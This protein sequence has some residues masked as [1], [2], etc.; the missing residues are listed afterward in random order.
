MIKREIKGVVVEMY[1]S[2]DELP[3][4]RFHKYNKF[5][6]IDSGVGSDINDLSAKIDTI[7]HYVKKENKLAITELENMRQSLYLISSELSPKHLAFAVLVHSINGEIQRDY[8]DDGLSK[9]VERLGKGKKSFI[10]GLI[11]SI[12]KKINQELELYFPGR[13]NDVH[14]KEYYDKL[15]ERTLLMLD[16]LINE[17]SNKFKIERIDD[18]LLELSKPQLFSGKESA[19]IKYDKQFNEMCIF[20]TEQLSVDVKKMSVLEF[21]NSFEYIKKSRGAKDKK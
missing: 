17:K 6:L 1:D 8:S 4:E 7:I 11:E 13:F 10:N 5:L 14:V 21:Y 15:K 3:I 12:K 16:E 9:I 18:F 2:I 19:E 20:L